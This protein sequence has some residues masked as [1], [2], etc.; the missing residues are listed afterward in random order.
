M[1]IVENIEL[2]KAIGGH[3]VIQRKTSPLYKGPEAFTEVGALLTGE[4][5]IT[6]C[7]RRQQIREMQSQWA[8]ARDT[9]IPQDDEPLACSTE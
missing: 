2:R 7:S 1:I 4:S 5:R 9:T 3:A 8:V 6:S